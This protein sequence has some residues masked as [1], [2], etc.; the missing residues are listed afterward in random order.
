MAI[1]TEALQNQIN[2]LRARVSDSENIIKD[3]EDK[4]SI[5]VTKS[6]LFAEIRSIENLVNDI[7][8]ALATIEN[9][10]AKVFLP[11]DTRFFLEES[12]ITDFRNNFRQ[13][14]ALT[15]DLE[16]S[17]QSFIKLASRFNL[18]NSQL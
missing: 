8:E 6:D 13:L 5:F 17:R 1:S 12:E 11:A 2:S 15:A 3:I 10:L 4:Q 16:K 18:T 14:R 7:N 9:K